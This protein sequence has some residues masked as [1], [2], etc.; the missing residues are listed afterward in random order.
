MR[1]KQFVCL[2]MIGL[3]A[4]LAACGSPP[5]AETETPPPVQKTQEFVAAL[6][7]R[8]ASQILALI[9]PTDWRNEMSPE[10]RSA[11]ALVESVSFEDMTYELQDGSTDQ[12]AQVRVTGTV[13]YTI[14]GAEPAQEVLDV[15]VALVQIDSE[16]YI[17]TFDVPGQTP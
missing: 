12:E 2:L 8:D 10:L 17:R 16:W 15:T 1:V 5:P 7:T 14:Q 11:L 13:N 4:L 6:S 3:L 9:E